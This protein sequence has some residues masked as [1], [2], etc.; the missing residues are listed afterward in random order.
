MTIYKCARAIAAF[1]F[2]IA[3]FYRVYGRQNIPDGG[4]LVCGN[5]TNFADPILAGVALDTKVRVRYMAKKELFSKKFFAWFLG[6]VGAFPVNRGVADLTA[7]KEAL[8]TL[9][10]GERL[11]MFPE[12]T[13][14]SDEGAKAGVGMLALRS[15]C[16]IL[17]VYITPGKRLFKRVRLII[18]EPYYPQKP[19][20]K[21]T[22][23]DYRRV[24]DECLEKINA[25]A[26][27]FSKT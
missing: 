4:V 16:P 17:P 22:Q 21:P 19:E 11:V 10:S 20:S 27:N 2:K 3:N 8:R 7:I 13:R 9:N 12:G 14:N 24:A 18:G 26:G 5:H 23:E 15:G 6:K 25:L 1:I